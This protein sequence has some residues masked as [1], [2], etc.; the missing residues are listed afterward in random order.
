LRR[1]LPAWVPDRIRWREK[2]GFTPPLPTWLRTVLRPQVEDCL[3]SFPQALKG[4]LDPAPAWSLLNRHLQ[5]ADCSDEL[6]RWMVLSR[7]C[8]DAALA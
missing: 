8:R 4:L 3:R 5:G 7:R 1:A 2:R 6:F